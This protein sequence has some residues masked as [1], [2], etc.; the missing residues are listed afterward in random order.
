MNPMTAIATAQAVGSGVKALKGGYN[1][2]NGGQSS[3]Y[4][5]WAEDRQNAEEKEYL[6]QLKNRTNTNAISDSQINRNIA[7]GTRGAMSQFNNQVN[8][9]RGAMISQGLGDSV[10]ATQMGLNE[11]QELAGSLNTNAMGIR[12]QADEFNINAKRQAEADYLKYKMALAN[13]KKEVRGQGFN[14]LLEGSLGAVSYINEPKYLAKQ[15]AEND[16]K[17]NQFLNMYR[18]DTPQAKFEYIDE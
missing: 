1:W 14:D 13:R 11:R 10:L 3:A 16:T 15:K 18:K 6:N 9:S 4:Y 7:H 2:L 17:W 5:P 12:K 8:E